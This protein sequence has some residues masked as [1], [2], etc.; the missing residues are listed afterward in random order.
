MYFFRLSSDAIVSSYVKLLS[1]ITH[2][3]EFVL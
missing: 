3:D 1:Q 2:S